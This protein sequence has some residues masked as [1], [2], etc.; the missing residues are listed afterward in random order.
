MTVCPD[1]EK[2]NEVISIHRVSKAGSETNFIKGGHI[3][4][5]VYFYPKKP[6][7]LILTTSKVVVFNLEKLEKV[8]QLS[9]G[10]NNYSCMSIHPEGG[11]IVVGTD[12]QKVFNLLCRFYVMIWT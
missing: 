4:R 1:N 2:K 11:Y 8:K 7:I 9:A 12:S 5:K 3:I 10:M 6:Q